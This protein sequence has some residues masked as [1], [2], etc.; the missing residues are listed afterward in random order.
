MATEHGASAE[1]SSS[2]SVQLPRLLDL[3]GV[4]EHLG[5]SERHVRRLVQERRIPFIKVGRFVRFDPE[6]IAT[7][8]DA[9]RIAPARSNPMLGIL[10]ELRPR[11]R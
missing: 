10:T 4:A 2:R 11:R 5:T 6:D 1:R 3:P 8:L 7:W 9:A